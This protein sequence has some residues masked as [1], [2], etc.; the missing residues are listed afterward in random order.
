M[1][2]FFLGLVVILSGISL[3]FEQLSLY[4]KKFNNKEVV[5]NS[6]KIFK[7]YLKKAEPILGIVAFVLGIIAF[8]A[9]SP[10]DVKTPT[11]VVSLTYRFLGDL[12]P[13]IFAIL[14]G[15]MINKK[16]LFIFNIA[17]EKVV[18]AE[19]KLKKY[20]VIIGILAIIIGFL[21]WIIGNNLLF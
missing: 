14:C 6:E 18:E 16:V 3:V 20:R 13:S 19:T 2:N 1:M 11:G 7:K 4:V 10:I 8:I 15:F 17:Q 9:P 12:I 21:H 5:I